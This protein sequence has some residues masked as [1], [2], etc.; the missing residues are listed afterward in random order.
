MYS[1]YFFLQNFKNVKRSMIP[2]LHVSKV[3]FNPPTSSRFQV[4]FNFILSF[5]ILAFE[6]SPHPLG[7]SNEKRANLRQS[8]WPWYHREGYLYSSLD[9][10]L[11]HHWVTPSIEFTFPHSYTQ[12][13]DGIGRLKC[14]TQE[15]N[16]MSPVRV[17][18]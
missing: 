1:T 2:F 11:V 8:K 7:T 15:H 10:M 12:L 9:G 3:F 18:N 13:E 17:R 4:K 16:T 5:K 6:V 14:V